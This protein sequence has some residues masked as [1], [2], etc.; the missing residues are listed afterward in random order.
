MAYAA[1]LN[2]HCSK[3]ATDIFKHRFA[4][5]FVE[6]SVID[7]ASFDILKH[8]GHSISNLAI[9][10]IRFGNLCTANEVAKYRNFLQYASHHGR[11]SVIN[12]RIT[13]NENCWNTQ[14]NVDIF[15]EIKSSFNRVKN[16]SIN[17][18]GATIKTNNIRLNKI[19]PNVLQLQLHF[20]S[21]T[22]SKFIA[23]KYPNLDKLSISG[24]LLDKSYDEVFKNLLLDNPQIRSVSLVHPTYRTFEHLKKYLKNLEEIEIHRSIRGEKPKEIIHFTSVKS[25]ILR[26]DRH[27]CHPLEGIKFGQELNELVYECQP[28]NAKY[29]NTLFT[30][31]QIK[32]LST[33]NSQ[34]ND[35][36]LLKLI[37][38]FPTLA[39]AE[40]SIDENVTV[41]SIAKFIRSN[42]NLNMLSFWYFS[43]SESTDFLKELNTSV[44]NDFEIYSLGN[45]TAA[46][47][48]VVKRKAQIDSAA[49]QNG[50]DAMILFC[51]T[52]IASVF[53]MQ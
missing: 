8:F 39:E 38:E 31:Q 18:R 26:F 48:V 46:N 29:F 24:R 30:Y 27:G 49:I 37:G 12:L 36:N 45:N 44:H 22:D 7:S 2:E 20:E 14:Y 25:L 9:N 3:V 52:L 50:F 41:D 28:Q 53:I 23:G 6:I 33:G 11:S 4:S 17:L 1:G 35:H 32:K 13:Y 5:D 42:K 15:N 10:L 19:I 21:L 16:A 43:K 51:T 34:W 47:F 40:F